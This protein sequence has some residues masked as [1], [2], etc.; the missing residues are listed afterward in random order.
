MD[1]IWPDTSHKER[2]AYY[3]AGHAVIALRESLE[4][5]RVSI[6]NEDD[7]SSWIDVTYPNLSQSRLTRSVTARS[8]A[9]SVIRALLAGPAAQSRYSFGAPS[10][11]IALPDFNL[12]D[13]ELLEAEPIWYAIALATKISN[14]SPSLI[15]SLWKRVTRL[16]RGDEVWTAIEAVAKA[17]LINGELAGCEVCDIANH[18]L[19]SSGR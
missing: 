1:D 12:A 4:V 16:I 6:Q 13:P 3:Q 9:K 14:D 10:A 17:L 15:H 2:D 19:R 8:D 7:A 11:H 18:A 5:V